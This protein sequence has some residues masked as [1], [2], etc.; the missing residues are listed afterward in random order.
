MLIYL[1]K[2]PTKY[3]CYILILNKL[4]KIIDQLKF[5]LLFENKLPV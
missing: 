2:F 5:P 3:S 1:N 4:F